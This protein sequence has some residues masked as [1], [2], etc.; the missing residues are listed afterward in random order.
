MK[1]NEEYKISEYKWLLCER[2]C[3]C[4][5]KYKSTYLLTFKKRTKKELS[6]NWV[7][8]SLR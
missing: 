5:K 4:A 3:Q 1:E 6:L 8:D 7:S 2:K